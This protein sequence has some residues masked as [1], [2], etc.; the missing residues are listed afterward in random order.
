MWGPKAA[1]PRVNKRRLI[2]GHH[3]KSERSYICWELFRWGG[4]GGAGKTGRH[5]G[6]AGEGW[7]GDGGH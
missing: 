4:G 2:R 7:G 1:A 6:E 5:K 3:K